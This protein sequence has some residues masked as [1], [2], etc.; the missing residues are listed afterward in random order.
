MVIVTGAVDPRVEEDAVVEAV[1]VS[2]AVD[3][4]FEIVSDK[5]T[6]VSAG[7]G[8]E[9]DDRTK[10]SANRHT[11]AIVLSLIDHPLLPETMVH[12]D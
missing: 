2:E 11:K 12:T 7:I 1:T 10:D 3:V 4:S 9:Q 8:L 6:E 5:L